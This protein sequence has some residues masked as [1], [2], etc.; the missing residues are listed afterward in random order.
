MLVIILREVHNLR[1]WL[2]RCQPRA[3]SWL[4]R[5]PQVGPA[6]GRTRPLGRTPH[7]NAGQQTVLAAAVLRVWRGRRRPARGRLLLA[8]C[9]KQLVS[10]PLRLLRRLLLHQLPGLLWL[11]RDSLCWLHLLLLRLPLLPR[12]CLRWL[13]L[14]RLCLLC[15]LLFLLLVR[16]CLLLL[17]G[18]LRRL[19][20]LLWCGWR[21]LAR[22]PLQEA[23]RRRGDTRHWRIPKQLSD[24][25]ALPPWK[26]QPHVMQKCSTLRS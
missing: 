11:C 2:A 10:R 21:L 5:R 25:T 18:L 6:T 26:H 13:M 17:L 7:T 4:S 8:C 23:G 20:G 12:E 9:P 22:G 1:L 19:L 24:K 3:G 14:S 15:W 16:L